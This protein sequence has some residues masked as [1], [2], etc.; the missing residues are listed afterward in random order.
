MSPTTDAINVIDATTLVAK[1]YLLSRYCTN[2][3]QHIVFKQEFYAVHIETL[4]F[5]DMLQSVI[6]S[7]NSISANIK[8][9]KLLL[10]VFKFRLSQK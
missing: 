10:A 2:T 6:A 3:I 5:T 8:T 4:V 1:L 9:D 7:I